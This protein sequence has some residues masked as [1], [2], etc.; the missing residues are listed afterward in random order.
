[1]L[2]AAPR[3]R[4]A[5][6]ASGALTGWPVVVAAGHGVWAAAHELLVFAARMDVQ[7]A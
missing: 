7:K 2:N 3:Q 1:V 4:T 5:S 6:G